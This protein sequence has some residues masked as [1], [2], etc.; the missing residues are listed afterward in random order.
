MRPGISSIGTTALLVLFM[1]SAFTPADT[2]AKEYTFSCTLA[3][4]KNPEPD[5]MGYKLFY[6]ANGSINS[7]GLYDAV[8][9]VKNVT[10]YTVSGL[11]FNTLYCF[12]VKAYDLSGAESPFSEEVWTS[13]AP[14]SDPVVDTDP[15]TD[16]QPV[17]EPDPPV[18]DDP[19][20]PQEAQ[21]DPVLPDAS[22]G[23]PVDVIDLVAIVG[24]TGTVS[25]AAGWNPDLD[26][27][28]NGVIDVADL[29]VAISDYS[30]GAGD[31]PSHVIHAEA[32]TGGVIF[33]ESS[34]AVADGGSRTFLIVAEGGY[35]ID[36]VLVDGLSV[37]LRGQYA[38]YRF[39]E[40]IDDHTIAVRFAPT[41]ERADELVL[42][43]DFNGDFQDASGWENHGF[44]S[45]DNMPAY[46]ADRYGREG[47]AAQ[48]DGLN[49]LV[50]VESSPDFNL[51]EYTLTAWVHGIRSYDDED[52][53]YIVSNHLK[54]TDDGVGMFIFS[55]ELC[56]C[57]TG[58]PHTEEGV[59]A[60]RE[61][62]WQHLAVVRSIWSV[63]FYLDGRYLGEV[64]SGYNNINSLDLIVGA[65]SNADATPDDGFFNGILDDVRLYSRPLSAEEI[66]GLAAFPGDV[67]RDGRVDESDFSL[68]AE[69]F[70][71]VEGDANWN[72]SADFDAN[73]QIDAADLIWAAWGAQ[74]LSGTFEND[75]LTGSPGDDLLTG[76]GGD[77]FLDGG[78]G[79]DTAAYTG[80]ALGYFVSQDSTGRYIVVDLQPA[81]GNDGRDV[82]ID[83]EYLQFTDKTVNIEDA[84][85]P[86]EIIDD[87]LYYGDAMIGLP[88]GDTVSAS[89]AQL[90]RLYYGAMRRMPDDAGY[91]WW[92]NQMQQGYHDLRS[93]SACFIAS[94]EFLGYLNAPDVDAI[95][96]DAFLTYMYQGVFGR[97]PD[98]EG[99]KWWLNQLQSGLSTKVDVFVEM[100]QSNEYVEQNLAKV[101]DYLYGIRSPLFR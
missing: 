26:L 16:P 20:P 98:M 25:S 94:P 54:H 13:M 31:G 101:V 33:S 89:E 42:R 8:I 76:F 95:S 22:P 23:A 17:T 81:D 80:A 58:V 45:G 100:L 69:A 99:Y 77:D 65:S 1:M 68:L 40:V 29:Q 9:D 60:G 73:G 71:S 28:G 41:A 10:Q 63:Q 44:S 34:A 36:E 11:E 47:K 37:G 19:A 91:A 90:F 84:I 93:V 56:T 92:L 64:P 70:G 39:H 75:T 66:Q 74:C 82:L 87:D 97:E 6:R 78:D 83:I 24:A 35:T 57:G 52:P 72:G 30:G 51:P 7:T 62:R 5:V 61:H 2:L 43:L 38:A 3:W 21:P 27:D 96:N 59:L 85:T 67:N 15:V 86:L 14:P 32:G 50:R 18:E 4:D 55:N 53:Q 48:F 88:N 79:T 49:D 12:T 46:A